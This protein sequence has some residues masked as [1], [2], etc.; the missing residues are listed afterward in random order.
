M[1]RCFQQGPTRYERFGDVAARAR[2]NKRS[3][4]P[5]AERVRRSDRHRVGVA[6][7]TCNRELEGAVLINGAWVASG[8]V[9]F[10]GDRERAGLVDDVD[11]G[12]GVGNQ[13]NVA[14]Q[15]GGGEARIDGFGNGAGSADGKVGQFDWCAFNNGEWPGAEGAAGEVAGAV[16]SDRECLCLKCCGCGSAGDVFVDR[17]RGGVERVL[18]AE[19][20]AGDG[21][22]EFDSVRAADRATRAAGKRPQR[23]HILGDCAGRTRWNER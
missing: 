8:D 11:M 5:Q 6:V 13:N 18:E 23:R 14:R 4:I 20:I 12:S 7:R 1:G 16:D 15:V 9:R 2:W 22:D 17:E 10:L 21:G 19:R 3:A